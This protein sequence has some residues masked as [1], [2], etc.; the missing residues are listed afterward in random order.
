MNAPSLFRF[1]NLAGLAVVGAAVFLALQFVRPRLTNPPV[2]ADLGAPAPVEQIL[3]TAC[4]NCHSNET[5]LAWFDKVV[6]A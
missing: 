3:R 4:Y 1:R 6:P 2:T 5:K